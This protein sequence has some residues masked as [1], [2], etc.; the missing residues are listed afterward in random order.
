VVLGYAKD[1]DRVAALRGVFAGTYP[2]YDRMHRKMRNI[3][4]T[5]IFESIT[6]DR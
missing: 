6:A 5:A 2:R 1:S 3:P 4:L